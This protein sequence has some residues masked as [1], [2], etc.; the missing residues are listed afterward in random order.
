MNLNQKII[1]DSN[2]GYVN[3]LNDVDVKLQGI[4]MEADILEE[5]N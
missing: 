4:K 5:N 1:S 3:I 2:L